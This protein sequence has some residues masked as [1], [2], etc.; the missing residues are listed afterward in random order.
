LIYGFLLARV[1]QL[2]DQNG[3]SLSAAHLKGPYPQKLSQS[4][5]YSFGH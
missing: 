1:S 3:I 2:S 5:L 4:M